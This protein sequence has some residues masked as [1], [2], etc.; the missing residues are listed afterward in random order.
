MRNVFTSLTAILLVVWYSLSVIGFDIHTCSGS[1]ETYVA[2]VASGFS[3]EDIHPDHEY[4]GCSCCHS[5][6]HSSESEETFETK[7]CCSD[8][9]HVIVLTGVRGD[10]DNS[11][12]DRCPAI[13]V[14]HMVS[15][16]Y[17][18]YS[19]Q[20]GRKAFLKPDSGRVPSGDIQEKYSIWRI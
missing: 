10:D 11:G 7:P 20:S 14:C 9:F 17:V 15:D 4:S 18:A 16:P 8:E 19:I 5:E 1:G 3:C 13:H 2:T 6:K 12:H